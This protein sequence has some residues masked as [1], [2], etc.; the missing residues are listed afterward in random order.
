LNGG[1][2]A[3]TA[4]EAGGGDGRDHVA[5]AYLRGQLRQEGKFLA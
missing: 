1:E 3:E 2:V 4:C 5:E